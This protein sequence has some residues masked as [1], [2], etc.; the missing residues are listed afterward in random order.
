MFE[1]FYTTKMSQDGKKLEKR[2]LGI[3]SGK[4]R[5]TRSVTA[6][7]LI[8]AVS[9]VVFSTIAMAAID[10]NTK[11]V[12]GRIS[13]DLDEEIVLKPDTE[14]IIETV[15]PV[16]EDNLKNSFIWPCDSTE[17]SA[18][19]SERIH[20]I[21]KEKTY[22]N[23]VDIVCNSGDSIYA[24]HDGNVTFSGYE[25]DKGNYIIIENDSIKTLYAHL[26]E[27]LAKEGD[28]VSG[29]DIIGKAGNTGMSTGAHLH[30]ELS[31]D[32]ELCNPVPH[33]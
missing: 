26:S 5:V 17:I 32:G 30:F 28:A 11:N 19:F 29:G 16:S 10:T 3:T 25:S 4:I 21:T 7:T 6:L 1:K 27:C 13:E 33:F 20:P 22:H 2:F 15:E 18:S 24:A 31:I 8:C 14:Q 23:G 9:L 12:E